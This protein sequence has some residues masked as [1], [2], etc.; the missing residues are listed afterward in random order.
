MTC[1][2]IATQI[3]ECILVDRFSVSP[4]H[5]PGLPLS[6]PRPP[7][8]RPPPQPLWKPLLSEAHFLLSHGFAW[9]SG[10]SPMLLSLTA[11]SRAG[12]YW[13]LHLAIG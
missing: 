10:V 11:R 4:A 3:R 7:G 12:D 13:Q 6:T 2:P 5:K 9:D 1:L 8:P